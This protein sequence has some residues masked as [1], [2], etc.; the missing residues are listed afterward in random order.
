M[1]TAVSVFAKRGTEAAAV[2]EIAAAANVS[3]GTF[4]YHF[5]DKAD[6]VDTVGHAIAAALVGQVD[7]EIEHLVNGAERVAAATRH[8]IRLASV[9]PEWGWLVVD[10]LS[11]MGTFYGQISE[12]IR[13]DVAIGVAQG[14][15]PVAPNDLLF[16]SLLAV[17]GVALRRRLENADESDIEDDAANLVLR[18]LGSVSV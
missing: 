8:F 17:V 13:K 16:T 2:S 6:L 11:D 5:K 9:E 1:D 14:L 10:A 12:G 7:R 18:M 15:F 4:Y 3:Q